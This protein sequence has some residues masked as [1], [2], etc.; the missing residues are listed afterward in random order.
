MA[1]QTY[2]K[3]LDSNLC[4]P[5]TRTSHR[6]G[7]NTEGVSFSASVVS[8]LQYG[9]VHSKEDY[10]RFYL[11]IVRP[12]DKMYQIGADLY[13]AVTC[14]INCIVR[15]SE[16]KNYA[17]LRELVSQ[18][19]AILAHG[20][21]LPPT[22]DMALTMTVQD[23]VV[24]KEVTKYEIK[25]EEVTKDKIQKEEV[26]PVQKPRPKSPSN[27]TEAL[28]LIAANPKDLRYVHR[29]LITK[30]FCMQAMQYHN[31]YCYRLLRMYARPLMNDPDVI[32][33][34]VRRNPNNLQFVKKTL[35]NKAVLLETEAATR[36]QAAKPT[37][38][39][40]QNL[41]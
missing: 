1:L 37:Q 33:E 17:S 6:G 7:L 18:I 38:S 10:S 32:L 40:L 35:R 4:D 23:H 3:I 41:I 13:F 30:S 12:Q 34:A 36:L 39:P 5:V 11:V 28:A 20:K 24:P 25:K 19:R 31:G 2:F 8:Q 14:E 9:V 15:M 16:L 27:E 29:H 26:K 22:T 21:S